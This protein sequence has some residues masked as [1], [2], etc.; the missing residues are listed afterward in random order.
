MLTCSLKDYSSFV[1]SKWSFELT[2]LHAEGGIE[3]R[4]RL[5]TLQK[6]D[7]FETFC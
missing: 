6:K 4:Y 2:C 1:V 5:K 7:F 3:N